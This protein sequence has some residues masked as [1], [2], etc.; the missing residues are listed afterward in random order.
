MTLRQLVDWLRRERG[1]EVKTT[2][3]VYGVILKRGAR[4]YALPG[5]DEDDVPPLRI[6]E[7]ICAA[8][9]LPYLDLGLDPR[10]DD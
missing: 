9:D 1:I 7:A 3:S 2:V 5:I 10:A 8:L 6:L 4:M